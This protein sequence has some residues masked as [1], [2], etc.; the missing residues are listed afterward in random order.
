[1]LLLAL[2]SRKWPSKGIFQ[3]FG[4]YDFWSSV[5]TGGRNGTKGKW[6][7]WKC[8]RGRCLTEILTLQCSLGYI[9]LMSPFIEMILWYVGL[10]ACLG[11]TVALCILSDIIALLTFHIYCFYVY[12]ARWVSLLG[13]LGRV[14]SQ[15]KNLWLQDGVS[16]TSQLQD[17][18]S[19]CRK[20][21]AGA[22]DT[23]GC[24][25]LIPHQGIHRTYKLIYWNL[26][27]N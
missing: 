9:H 22:G 20:Q 16:N 5:W 15:S 8:E 24:C 10:S 26:W 23:R 12:G 6:G 27:D 25:G 7:F 2:L 13:C 1:M 17:G 3:W 11:L 19:K 21:T 4:G 18:P 14:C